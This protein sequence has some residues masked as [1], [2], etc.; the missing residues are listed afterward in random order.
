MRKLVGA[1]LVAGF[2]DRE[3]ILY[4]R[5]GSMEET[6]KNL[7]LL[8]LIAVAVGCGGG[9]SPTSSNCINVAGNWAASFNNSCRQSG[10]TLVTV[11]QAGCN[12]AAGVAGQG[13]LNGTISGSTATFTLTYAPPCSGTV[14]GTATV[15]ADTINGT[16]SGRAVGCCDPV[17][18]SFTLTR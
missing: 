4:A 7:F 6:M 5:V 17:S 16:Y 2:T 18:G 13:T 3:P 9:S 14:S 8:F 12:F 11:T 1:L 15:S 10:T